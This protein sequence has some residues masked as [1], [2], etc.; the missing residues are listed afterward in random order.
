MH[1]GHG[2]PSIHSDLPNIGNPSFPKFQSIPAIPSH[3]ASECSHD[4]Y[5]QS[6]KDQSLGK[7]L[8]CTLSPSTGSQYEQVSR[9]F[10]YLM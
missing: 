5:S 1:R 6:T 7:K 4:S 8:I 3:Y 9:V 2:G 10:I